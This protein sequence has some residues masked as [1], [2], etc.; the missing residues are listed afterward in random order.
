VPHGNRSMP[1][2]SLSFFIVFLI[3]SKSV[4]VYNFRA[5]VS[6]YNVMHYLLALTQVPLFQDYLCRGVAQPGSAL[7][8]GRRGRRFNSSHPDH[9]V[10]AITAVNRRLSIIFITRIKALI[11]A[12]SLAFSRSCSNIF[13]LGHCYFQSLPR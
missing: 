10:I 11:P 7:R 2:P 5:N 6:V 4:G 1:V 8:S 9:S 12:T 3:I 13:L